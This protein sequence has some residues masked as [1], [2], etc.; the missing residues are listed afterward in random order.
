MGQAVSAVP[1]DSARGPGTTRPDSVT[2]GGC[3]TRSQQ[4]PWP[5]KG[6]LLVC[7]HLDPIS[8]PHA[9]VKDPVLIIF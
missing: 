3:T 1:G 4:P 9:N 7:D 6:C 5:G 8:H 2:H